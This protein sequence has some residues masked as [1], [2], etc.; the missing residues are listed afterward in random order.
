MLIGV[1]SDT[2][3]VIRQEAL[4]ALRGSDLIV[5][6]GDVGKESVLKTL[7]TIAPVFAVRGNIDRAGWADKL[8]ETRAVK[9]EAIRIYVLHILSDLSIDP[10]AESYQMVI[11]GH[12][13]MPSITGK[14]GVVFLNP[15][16]AGP[17]RFRLPVSIAL[18]SISGSEIK[19][20]IVRLDGSPPDDLPS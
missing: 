9:V 3:G 20:R 14:N 4:D 16:S 2:H 17:R 18:A 19:A 6:A 10:A 15:G 8:P 5:H 7:E 11:S 1:I 13:H 12:S